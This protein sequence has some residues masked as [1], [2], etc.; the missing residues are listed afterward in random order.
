MTQLRSLGAALLA[1]GAAATPASAA[2]VVEGGGSVFEQAVSQV[3][4]S[5]TDLETRSDSWTGAARDLHASVFAETF[6]GEPGS[7]V[8]SVI[9][10]HWNSATSGTVDVTGRG[11][12][13]LGND[14][15]AHIV[16]GLNNAA[17]GQD[18]WSYSF[19]VLRDSAMVIAPEFIGGG[20]HD[21]GLGHWDLTFSED[22]GPAVV[23]PLL[24]ALHP[25]DDIGF[26]SFL[27]FHAGHSYRVALRSA[28][29]NEFIGVSPETAAETARFTWKIA[30]DDPGVPEPSTWGLSI[31]GFGLSGAALRRRPTRSRLPFSRSDG[32]AR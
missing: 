28:E 7:A 23:L 20:T 31:L 27:S 32:V 6:S 16:V 19:D 12:Q 24:D 1:A 11:W 30:A 17:S 4:N 14:P 21:F 2:V 5:P 10:A 3:N 13:V 26:E 8:A 9:N 18:D 29:G 15:E 25:G 22:G